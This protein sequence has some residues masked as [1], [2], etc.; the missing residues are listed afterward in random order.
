MAKART[1]ATTTTN[2]NK[3]NVANFRAMNSQFTV[4]P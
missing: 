1:T 3:K 2:S 4:S